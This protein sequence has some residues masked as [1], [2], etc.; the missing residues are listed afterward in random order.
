MKRYA[1]TQFRDQLPGAMEQARLEPVVV[2][3]HGEL[4]VV[5]MSVELFEELLEAS[6]ELDDIKA[7]DEAMA[8]EGDTLPWQEVRQ[9]LGW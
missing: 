2:E 8:E 3:C 7:F 5:M 1:V 6:E 4:A 9:E